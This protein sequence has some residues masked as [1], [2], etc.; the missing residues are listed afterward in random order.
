M[1]CYHWYKQKC[2]NCNNVWLCLA[3]LTLANK[4]QTWT[5]SFLSVL[6]F[7]CHLLDK[8]LLFFDLCLEYYIYSSCP[9]SPYLSGA[10]WTP[11]GWCLY[12]ALPGVVQPDPVV[13]IGQYLLAI[14]LPLFIIDLSNG[15]SRLTS[16]RPL[17]SNGLHCSF[18]PPVI[19]TNHHF[20]IQAVGCPM[21]PC[22][23]CLS[24]LLP[25]AFETDSSNAVFYLTWRNHLGC[26]SNYPTHLIQPLI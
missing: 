15:V 13:P 17:S 26:L 9:V 22:N 18:I 6:F 10:G 1:V 3:L 25:S 2:E 14:L 5:K 12:E 19:P 23:Q 4:K 16:M 24:L 20:S 21:W 8:V 7:Y 11:L